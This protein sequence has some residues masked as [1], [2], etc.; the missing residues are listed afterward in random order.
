MPRLNFNV[1]YLNEKGDPIMQPKIDKE[2]TEKN[3]GAT[4]F[5]KDVDGNNITE[6]VLIKDML[7]RVMMSHFD[8]DKDMD[9]DN[10][11]K[12]GKLIRR[13]QNSD[14]VNYK[15]DELEIIK[16]LVA[17]SNTNVLLVAQVDDIINSETPYFGKE[18][19]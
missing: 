5:E 10:K 13:I 14:E 18:A 1:P 2:K 11:S 8:G 19:A 3:N 17:K 15:D 9:F 12:R 6:P 16:T 4:V 7:V